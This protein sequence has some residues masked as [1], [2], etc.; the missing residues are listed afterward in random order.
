MRQEKD[1]E[2]LTNYK[3]K[4]Y[5]VG[6]EFRTKEALGGYTVRI[7]GRK[8]IKKKD[9]KVYHKYWVRFLDECKHERFV[10][11]AMLRSGGIRNPYHRAVYGVGFIGDGKYVSKFR[12]G[13]IK[14]YQLWQGMLERCYNEAYRNKYPTYKGCYVDSEWH[15]FQNFAEWV[16]ENYPIHVVDKGYK[17][18][19]D[20]DLLSPKGTKY[21]SK[22]TCIFLPESINNYIIHKPV[23]GVTGVTKIHNKYRA[24]I[25]S[26]IRKKLR[27]IG[28]YATRE[29]AYESYLKERSKTVEMYRNLL[30]ELGY[31][32]KVV[33]KLN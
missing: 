20:K 4:K 33:K 3:S 26:P 17:V 19:F 5:S 14:V 10:R 32:E 25:S 18:A 28:M 24:H 12:H 13:G 8:S 11:S 2:L 9:G 30:R 15:N 1:S 23:E 22:Y 29:L 7:L 31:S 6:V 21:Y 16:V 27:Y